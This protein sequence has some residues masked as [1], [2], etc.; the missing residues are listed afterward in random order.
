M[1]KNSPSL[2]LEI[3]SFLK[4]TFEVLSV[5]SLFAFLLAKTDFLNHLLEKLKLEF[6]KS[7]SIGNLLNLVVVLAFF[8]LNV[9]LIQILIDE[10][11]GA[12]KDRFGFY[13]RLACIFVFYTV[14]LYYFL[15]PNWPR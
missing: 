1:A 5:L 8:G 6:L 13:S 3:K 15:T 9:G 12:Y 7:E 4:H 10:N 2:Y 14:C 11:K